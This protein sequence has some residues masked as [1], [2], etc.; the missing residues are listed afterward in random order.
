MLSAGLFGFVIFAF[1]GVSLFVVAVWRSCVWK[2]FSALTKQGLTYA[3][4]TLA[5]LSDREHTVDTWARVPPQNT[6]VRACISFA[7]GEELLAPFFCSYDLSMH[8]TFY[9]IDPPTPTAVVIHMAGCGNDTAVPEGDL[10]V[11]QFQDDYSSTSRQ[12]HIELLCAAAFCI[13]IMCPASVVAAYCADEDP[14]HLFSSGPRCCR[15]SGRA[16]CS[17]NKENNDV[18]MAEA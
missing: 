12:M 14:C 7:S 10:I 13:L 5:P 16:C 8:A 1:A 6:T 11:G 15:R 2:D 18:E 17:R 9:I 4:S 3:N